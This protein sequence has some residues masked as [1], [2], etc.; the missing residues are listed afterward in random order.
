MSGGAEI[1]VFLI[2]KDE[3]LHG[4]VVSCVEHIQACVQRDLFCPVGSLHRFFFFF[5]V[6]H[7]R[8][9]CKLF[10]LFTSEPMLNRTR[11]F[12]DFG[13]S[14][15]FL[16]STADRVFSS[17][18]RGHTFSIQVVAVTSRTEPVLSTK[19]ELSDP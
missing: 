3:L 9:V 15:I 13:M 10:A 14:R 16:W 2:G 11:V 17:V 19:H 7:G 6:K 1:S 8:F 4:Y 18:T 12:L 5:N